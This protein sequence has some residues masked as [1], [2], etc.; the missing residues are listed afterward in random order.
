[1]DS[2]GNAPIDPF[3]SDYPFH[4]PPGDIKTLDNDDNIWSATS[5]ELVDMLFGQ[6]EDMADFSLVL[7]DDRFRLANIESAMT[8]FPVCSPY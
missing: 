2:I 8:L 3:K 7:N 5:G 4:D 6:T 1:M